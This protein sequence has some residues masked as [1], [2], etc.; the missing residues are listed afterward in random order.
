VR[1]L[2]QEFLPFVFPDTYGYFLILLL[3]DGT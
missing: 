3:P 1:P 2:C